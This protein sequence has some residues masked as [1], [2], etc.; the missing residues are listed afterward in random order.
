MDI[1]KIIHIDMDAFYAS[2]EERDFP[3][4]RGVPL[5]V[6]SPKERGVVSTANYEARKYG[7]RSAMSS[8]VAMLKCPIL[9]FQP[10]RFEVYKEVSAQIHRIFAEYTDMVEPLSLDEAYL[11]VTTNK[12]NM[13]SATIIAQEI[14]HKIYE[15]THLTASAG[16]SYNKFLA[17][18]ASD[19]RKPNGLFVILPHQAQ[20]FLMTL[21]VEKFY[22][23][24]KVTANHLH[25]MNIYTGSDLFKKNKYEMVQIFGKAGLYFYDVVRG[26]D[27][28][29]VEPNRE[30]K[31]YSVET[32]FEKDLTT[33]FAVIAELYALEQRLWKDV[34]NTGKS[35]RTLTL[36]IRFSDFTT[37]TRS[38][39]S[40]VPLLS[41][42]QLHKTA[43]R[44]LK[45]MDY[46]AKPIRLLGVGI[47][48]L[49]DDTEIKDIQLSMDF[50][51]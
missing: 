45:R 40:E 6:G 16:V 27:N 49:I 43:K 37:L 24:G 2:V 4:L 17:K 51:D 1:R 48:N 18:I 15:Q 42:H 10:P 3:H 7:V 30:R 8:K 28:R 14:K 38:H 13:P 34:E 9:R 22:G 50:E 29:A 26:V 21:P 20:D 11:D 31:S 44:M 23:I 12:K 32:T 33:S 35:G 39:S 5:A 36:K 47:S 41:F 25:E 46:N 19:Y